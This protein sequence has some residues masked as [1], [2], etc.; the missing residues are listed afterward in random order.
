V[1]TEL[2]CSILK[3][4]VRVID[5][6]PVV[7]D[8]VGEARLNSSFAPMS[9]AELASELAASKPFLTRGT[10]I[11]GVGSKPSQ[12]TATPGPDLARLFGK[13]SSGDEANRLALHDPQTYKK[14]RAQAVKEGRI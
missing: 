7:L 11:G 14:L 12:G 2:A 3:S 13:G 8:S 5:G 9:I 4:S 1:D 10:V 6:K